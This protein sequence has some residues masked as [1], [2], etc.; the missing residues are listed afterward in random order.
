MHSVSHANGL[1]SMSLLIYNLIVR[2][3]RAHWPITAECKKPSAG[4][5]HK[6][7]MGAMS[8]LYER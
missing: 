5:D 1:I 7:F 3:Q 6:I 8:A 4:G 2:E